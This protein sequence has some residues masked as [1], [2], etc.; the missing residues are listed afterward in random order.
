[1]ALTFLA[2]ALA[3]G[4]ALAEPAAAPPPKLKLICREGVQQTGSRI[5]TGRRCKTAEQWQQEDA[6]RDH[7]P[8]TLRVTKGQEDGRPVQNPQ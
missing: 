4:A 7:I 2:I 6:R 1:M 5:R 3:P 8:T